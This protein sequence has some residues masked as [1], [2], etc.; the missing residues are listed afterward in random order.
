MS[1]AP[2]TG[3]RRWRGGLA[4]RLLGAQALVLLAGAATAWVVASVVAPGIFH[5]HLQRAGV[6]HTAAETL[7]VERAFSDSLIIALAVALV[8]SVLMALA[9]TAY[10]TTRVQR[11]TA[12]VAQSAAA[13]ADGQ[14]G[15]RV[16]S[17]GLGAEF[18]DLAGTINTL[19]QRLGDVETTRRRIL[20]DLAHEMR[21]PLASIEAH[22]EAVEDG[23]RDLD[24]PTLAVLRE[25]TGRLRR[26]AEDISAVS[27]AEEG[28]LESR[29]VRTPPYL[30]V[31][32]AVAAAA[33]AYAAKGVALSVE[34]A[35]TAA[36]VLVDRQRMGQV[37]G[38]LLDNALRHTPPGG[39]V[40]LRVHQPDPGWVELAVR[41]T[42]EGIAAEHLPHLFE[43]FYR[44]DPARGR[45]NGGS[46]IGL[47]ISRA[48]VEAHGGGI[49]ATSAGPGQG[50]TFTVRLPAAP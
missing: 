7:H 33:D 22:L 5:T 21:T 29:P 25:G 38:N 46:G 32:A 17:P 50:A 8:T 34:G 45:A 16:P 24:E 35:T 1:P 3:K 4:A 31:E 44:A 14:Y 30:L 6:A 39:A 23:V 28:R 48:L 20:A 26:L 13:I 15:A 19:G 2:R 12:A 36:A 11:S 49:S 27:R 42:G 18:D 9:V 47:T 43:R 40:Y 10:F 37:L 41:D